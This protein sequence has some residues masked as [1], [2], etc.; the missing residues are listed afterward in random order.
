M[1][2]TAL[3]DCNAPYGISANDYGLLAIDAGIEACASIS[4]LEYKQMLMVSRA[5]TFGHLHLIYKYM[6]YICL[7]L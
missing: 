2:H 1:V 7:R 6:I 5:Y 4:I 3:W